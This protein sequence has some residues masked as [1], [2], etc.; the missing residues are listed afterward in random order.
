VFLRLFES[1][2]QKFVIRSLVLDPSKFGMSSQLRFGAPAAWPKP[3]PL[4][5]CTL[6]Q[7]LL[8]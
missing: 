3:L 7:R 4:F 1:T 8:T 6:S 2:C 5:I